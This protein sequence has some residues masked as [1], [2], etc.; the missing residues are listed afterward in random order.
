MLT[1]GSKSI[2]TFKKLELMYLGEYKEKKN[3]GW[4]LTWSTSINKMY[5]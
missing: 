3:A 2:L 5:F 4:L 1:K